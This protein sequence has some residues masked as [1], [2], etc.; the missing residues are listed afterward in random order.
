MTIKKREDM[1]KQEVKKL[2]DIWKKQRY[3]TKETQKL[4]HEIDIS[5]SQLFCGML[6]SAMG[7]N[8]HG[9]N[10]EEMIKPSGQ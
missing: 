6:T 1:Y 7:R 2:Q 10:F 8:S 4:R 5:G 9:S 3:G